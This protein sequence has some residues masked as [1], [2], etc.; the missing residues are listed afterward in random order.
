[1]RLW[2]VRDRHMAL[3]KCVLIGWLILKQSVTPMLSVATLITPASSTVAFSLFSA[4]AKSVTPVNKWDLDLDLD[5]SRIQLDTSV[6]V[7]SCHLCFLP[8]EPHLLSRSLST[9]LLHFVRGRPAVV[10]SCI[11]VPPS[12]TLAVVYAGDPFTSRVQA[13][14]VV[15]LSVCCPSFVV[16][17]WFTINVL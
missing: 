6:S 9:V 7:K 14:E 3:Y 4:L 15:F 12:T 1:M 11:L 5:L 10:L 8:A 16:Q 17:F 2:F 13:S